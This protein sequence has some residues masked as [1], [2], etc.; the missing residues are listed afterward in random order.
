MALSGF[1]WPTATPKAEQPAES[2]VRSGAGT[3]EPTTSVSANVSI[4]KGPAVTATTESI[5][6]I[7]VSPISIP[8]A[9]VSP[10][11]ADETVVGPSISASALSKLSNI[12]QTTH[13]QV[14]STVTVQPTP[15]PVAT[16]AVSNG[17]T[18]GSDGLLTTR[19]QITS[20]VTVQSSAPEL[21]FGTAFQLTEVLAGLPPQFTPPPQT[22]KPAE[23][24]NYAA[25]AGGIIGG[26]IG[27]VLLLVMIRC[28]Q[29]R[30][31]YPDME[32]AQAPHHRSRGLTQAKALPPRRQ[33]GR[34][35]AAHNAGNRP[36]PQSPLANLSSEGTYG[37]NPSMLAQANGWQR[38]F[39]P[40]N[41]E[42]TP[43]HGGGSSPGPSYPDP[44]PAQQ[45]VWGEHAAMWERSV[46]PL[47][48]GGPYRPSYTG[49]GHHDVSPPDSPTLGRYPY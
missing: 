48:S 24:V 45:R 34:G 49:H 35:N 1:T 2:A 9:P 36:A 6:S 14:T 15:T 19:V 18:L 26:I 44:A 40:N 16:A 22:A 20:T 29:K 23:P 43:V 42:L 46:S 21:P 28:L 47:S 5:A 31:V 25:I 41:F 37:I 11:A 7:S 17:H 30:T 12:P 33:H 39:A 8:V 10:S 38:N 13:V 32:R 4:A 3:P 27:V